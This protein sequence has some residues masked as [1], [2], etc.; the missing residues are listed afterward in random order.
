MSKYDARK[1]LVADND[2]DVLV[3][4]ERVLEDDGYAT[5]TAISSA[6]MCK[7]LS[8]GGF[9]LLVLDDSLSDNHSVQILAECRKLGIAVLTVVT[10]HRFPSMEEET[11][12]R[13]LGVCALVNKQSHSELVELAHY[14]LSPCGVRNDDRFHN[15]T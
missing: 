10:Y 13:D 12:L 3:A 8:G 15:T 6:E 9:D 14:L 5:T 1:I 2:E 11:R 7:L 4:L